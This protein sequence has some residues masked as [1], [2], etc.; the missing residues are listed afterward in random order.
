MNADTNLKTDYSKSETQ[1]DQMES[2]NK[3]VNIYNYTRDDN[4][5]SVPSKGPNL[6]SV[7][8]KNDIETCD[9]LKAFF[10]KVRFREFFK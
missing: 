6:C 5:L 2:A 10:R 7:S 8:Q 9:G 1:H 4:K 3:D